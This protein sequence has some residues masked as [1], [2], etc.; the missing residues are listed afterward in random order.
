MDAASDALAEW[1]QG[2]ESLRA[3]AAGRLVAETLSL[4]RGYFSN[5]KIQ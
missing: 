3:A 4:A 2:G 1:L 5:G